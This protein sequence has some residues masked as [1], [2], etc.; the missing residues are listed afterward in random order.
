MKMPIVL[1][2]SVQVVSMVII[3]HSCLFTLRLFLVWFLISKHVILVHA[4]IDVSCMLCRG[5]ES[6]GS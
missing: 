1:S 2:T 3:N 6:T 5:G 4:L